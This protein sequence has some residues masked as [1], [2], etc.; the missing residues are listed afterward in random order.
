MY[1]AGKAWL[2]AGTTTLGGALLGLGSVLGGTIAQTQSV[3]AATE[4]E[5][6]K[7]A[8]TDDL[9]ATKA[10]T[11]IPTTSV[12][13]SESTTQSTSLSG[14]LSVST[15]Q[16]LSSSESVSMSVSANAVA[17]KSN[18]TSTSMSNSNSSS[19]VASMSVSTSSSQSA[20]TSAVNDTT[21]AG[22]QATLNTNGTATVTTGTLDNGTGQLQINLGDG[23]T[24][25]AAQFDV[26]Q[27]YV[28]AN[29][30]SLLM[31]QS[32]IGII[33]NEDNKITSIVG[34]DNQSDIDT[35][36]SQSAVLGEAAYKLTGIQQTFNAIAS[37]AI[38]NQ[39]LF[40]AKAS[41]PFKASGTAVVWAG[42]V[43]AGGLTSQ[44]YDSTIA[45][46]NSAYISADYATSTLTS[47]LSGMVTGL[48]QV[49]NLMDFVKTYT[50]YDA[51]Q[52]AIETNNTGIFSVSPDTTSQYQVGITIKAKVI[53][54]NLLLLGIIPKLVGGAL[55]LLFGANGI[56]SNLATVTVLP[57]P[58]ATTDVTVKLDNDYLILGANVD[59]NDLN[60]KFDTNS[61]TAHAQ[62]NPTNSTEPVTWTSSDPSIATINPITGYI[63]AVGK[64]T[65][66]ITA[67]SGGVTGT[68]TL[69]IGG[70]L[71]AD[72]TVLVNHD[73]TFTAQGYDDIAGSGVTGITVTYQW[74]SNTNGNNEI[75]GSLKIDGATGKTYTL[76]NAQMD[77]NGTYYFV[78]VTVNADHVKTPGGTINGTSVLRSNFASLT[79]LPTSLTGHDQTIQVGEKYDTSKMYTYIDANGNE[80]SA[81]VNIHVPANY[82]NTKP[83][84]YKFELTYLDT[85]TNTLLTAYA[86][87]TVDGTV[88]LSASD[89][90]RVSEARSASEDAVD[91]DSA[92]TSNS[93]VSDSNT[94][95]SE[96]TKASVSKSNSLESNSADS[97]SISKVKS[98]SISISGAASKAA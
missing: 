46:G 3:N 4:S 25:T 23:Q 13:A 1:K 45:E 74:Y 89:S 65:V 58:V 35:L 70:G 15:S 86:Y 11:T 98:E 33:I 36:I 20:S 85:E 55:T 48:A 12:T 90:K 87:V 44:P 43:W 5:V 88:S 30:I 94:L 40:A 47:L 14:S 51:N 52:N 7:T 80:V 78:V 41:G 50:L 2:V 79:V 84:T 6:T 28:V 91:S 60:L 71:P 38:Q 81:S 95:S 54:D 97:N 76:S 61:T 18:S 69:T 66:I 77:Q 37:T 17:N 73:A 22:L 62:L 24:L 56:Y 8:S 9:L 19:L 96:S 10:S 26:I 53:G 39:A 92:S 57:T 93:I 27:R 63:T 68:A 83:G 59:Q 67:T 16:S 72:E 42:I 31:I 64:G 34:S 82:D 21:T 32:A 29:N 75:K 49:L